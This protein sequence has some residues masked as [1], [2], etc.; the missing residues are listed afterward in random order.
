MTR[1]MTRFDAILGGRPG[2]AFRP[3]DARFEQVASTVVSD[4]GVPALR[5]RFHPRRAAGSP[6]LLLVRHEVFRRKPA[7]PPLPD[8]LY[9]LRF[10]RL[11]HAAQLEPKSRRVK[12]RLS[13]QR[14]L[15]DRSGAVPMSGVESFKART[16]AVRAAFADIEIMIDDLIVEGHAIAWRWTL[17]G[18]HVGPFA[19]VEP[20]GR[21]VTLRGV[22]FQRLKDDRVIE[23]WTMVDVFGAVR[24][25]RS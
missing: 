10:R 20:T 11:R 9:P 22:N 19:G 12:D 6:G 15:I 5:R 4:R 18:T 8:A 17:N 7:R 14:L 2:G 3:N 13:V 1:P 16:G 24:A 23:H 21:R 25:L